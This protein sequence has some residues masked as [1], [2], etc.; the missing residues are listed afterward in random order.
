MD[1]KDIEKSLIKKY[2]KEIWGKFTSG[3]KDYD[4]IKEGDK[5]A[6]A[7]SGGKDSLILAKLL[8]E[9]QKHGRDK[10]ELEFI[11]MDPGFNDENRKML[12]EN[13]KRLEIP[14]KIRESRIFDIVDEISKDQPCYLCARMRRGFLYNFARELGCNKLALGHH[15]NDV[16]ETTMLNTFYAYEFKTMLPKIKAKNHQ[17]M[18]LIRPMYL[19]KEESIIRWKNYIDMEFMDCGCT[20]ACK[21]LGGK[22]KEIKNFINEYKKVHPDIDRSIFEAACNVNLDSIVGSRKDGIRKTYLEEKDD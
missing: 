16:I 17:N 3:L 14:V 22:R 4:L 13:C 12:E 15:F 6:V 20:V 19:V 21:V 10:I 1:I 5:I 7:I 2:R 8:Q 11:S 9:L 18:E